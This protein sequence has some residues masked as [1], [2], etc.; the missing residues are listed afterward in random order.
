MNSQL[1]RKV[2]A[3]SATSTRFM[4]ARKAG[5][6]GRTR[7]GCVFVPAVAEAV[8]ARAGTAEID[9]GEEEG[10]QRVDPE[11]RADPRDAER[12]RQ[13]RR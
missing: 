12:Q 1:H 2:K 3:S 13:A 6:K 7:C 10:R 5:K 11:M 8:E 4:P 9:D